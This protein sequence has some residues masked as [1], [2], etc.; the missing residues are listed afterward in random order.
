MTAAAPAP[1]DATDDDDVVAAARA[2]AVD[3]AADATRLEREGVTRAEVQAMADAGLLAVTGPPELGGVPKPAQRE[4]AEALAGASPDAW[5]VWFQ[6]G[7]VVKMLSASD[8]Q[9]LKD[10]Y[11]PGLCRGEL[12]G[13]V[14]WSNLR[15]ARPSVMATRVDGGWSLSG[16]QPW[17]TGWGLLDVVLVGGLDREHG[18][19]VF[20]IVDADDPRLASAGLL[21]LAAMSGTSTHAVRYEGLHLREDAVVLRASFDGW[22]QIDSTANQNVQPSTFGIAL[23]SLDLL[24]ERAEPTASALRARVVDVRSRAYALIDDV[25]PTERGD[26][27]LALRAE[28]LLLAIECC[29]ALLASRGG[30]GMGLN[31]PAQRLLRAA[32]FQL[33]HSQAEH[34]R[35]ET[36]AQL[37]G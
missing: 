22:A 12:Q 2:L 9:P 5:F 3:L 10:R 1:A 21:D 36:L 16:F 11:L 27:R 34:I 4:V 15:T 29:T 8:N 26:E 28:A 35:Q 6:H 25:D 14:A 23:A 32:A 33:V 30:R 13:G 37:A 17:C 18:E 19:V 20:G 31:D 24:A 7:P